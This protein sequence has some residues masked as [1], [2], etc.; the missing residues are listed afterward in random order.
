MAPFPLVRSKRNPMS[1]HAMP[2]GTRTTKS[3]IFSV[4]TSNGRRS[5]QRRQRI[6]N[7]EHVTPS[8]LAGWKGGGPLTCCWHDRLEPREATGGFRWSM[9]SMSSMSSMPGTVVHGREGEDTFCQG[10]P[11]PSPLL[12]PSGHQT[13]RPV[14][15]GLRLGRR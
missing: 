7:A 11:L 2:L 12:A 1:S 3:A 5:R 14:A 4:E 10:P 6:T 13:P 9:S 15:F 8:H